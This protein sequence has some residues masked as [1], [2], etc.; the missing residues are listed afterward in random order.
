MGRASPRPSG[1]AGESVLFLRRWL[2]VDGGEG[3]SPIQAA[4]W[5]DIKR[6][7]MALRPGL[8]RVYATVRDLATYAPIVTRLRFRR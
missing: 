3:P 5:L 8:R 2:G 1:A 6:T 7:Y 4:G